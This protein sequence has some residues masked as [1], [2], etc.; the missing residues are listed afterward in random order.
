MYSIV[1]PD[2]NRFAM[3]R[4]IVVEINKGLGYT[5]KKLVR[6]DIKAR[7]LQDLDT[8]DDVL[9]QLDFYQGKN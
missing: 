1:L 6:G 8:F 9:E 3:L 7:V 2:K 5:V 4:E